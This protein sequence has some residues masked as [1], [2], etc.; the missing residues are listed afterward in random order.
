MANGNEIVRVI[1]PHVKAVDACGAGATF[2]AGFI[3]GYLKGWNLEKSARFATAAASLKVTHAGLQMFP[4]EQ[5]QELADRLKVEHWVFKNDRFEILEKILDL[6][7]QVAVQGKKAQNTLMR[8]LKLTTKQVPPKV[9][10]PHARTK[11][12]VI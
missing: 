3:Y 7:R 1:A 10:H 6:P 8:E 5:I 12:K 2:S 11:R 9:N 4:L